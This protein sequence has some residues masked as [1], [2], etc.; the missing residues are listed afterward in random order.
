[1]FP[2]FE[3]GGGEALQVY[4]VSK[5]G[6]GGHKSLGSTIFPIYSPL[7]GVSCSTGVA[8]SLHNHKVLGSTLG[9]ALVV[10]GRHWKFPSIT[11][12]P[13]AMVCGALSMGHCT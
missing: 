13:K 3:G 4:P 10:T 1:M 2:S 9:G 7:L 8:S 6:G 11:E 5:G 12:L